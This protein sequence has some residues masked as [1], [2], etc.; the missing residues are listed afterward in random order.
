M[1]PDKTMRERVF[2][3][4]A[5]KYGTR[6]EYLFEKLPDCA[7]LR[8]YDNRKWYAIIMSVRR[9][10][11]GGGEGNVDVMNVKV[12]DPFIIESLT[13]E[14]GFYRAYH[15]SKS[16]WISVFLDGTVGEKDVFALL[17]RSYFVTASGFRKRKM[18]DPKEWI[19]PANPK[20]YDIVH[21]FDSGDTIEWKQGAGI[22]RGDT[23]F[24]YV[25][26]PVSAIMF[27]CL[28]TET[29]IPYDYSDGKLQIRA[30]MKIK[31]IRRYDPDRFTFGVLKDEYGVNAVRGPR[32]IPYSLLCE[33][34]NGC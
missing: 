9:S 32:G 4:A 12:G 23:V 27:K 2:E 24:I 20:Y 1:M 3:Y 6:P 14:R 11:F 21:A 33:L 10:K 28:V 8:H 5:E 19:V 7:V 16:E 31:L 17:D 25:G 26:A 30:L 15:M 29:D 13:A 22:N 34:N 18:R